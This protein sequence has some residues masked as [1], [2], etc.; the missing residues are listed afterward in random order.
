M[1][2]SLPA[3]TSRLHDTAAVAFARPDVLVSANDGTASMLA[4][5]AA[6]YYGFWNNGSTALFEATV[7]PGYI[8]CTLPAGRQQGPIGLANAG[9]AF[10]AAFPDGRVKVLQQMLVGDRIV[11]HLRV[12]GTFTGSRKGAEGTG[13]AINYLATDIMRVADGL[14]VENWHVEDHETLHQQLVSPS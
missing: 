10:F 14:I 7:S 5:L 3:D 4:E 9:A 11:S 2:T 1:A 12:T 6:T 8:D 13:Q